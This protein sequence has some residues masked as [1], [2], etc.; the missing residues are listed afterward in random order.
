MQKR[1]SSHFWRLQFLDQGS[2]GLV[3][4]ET[5]LLGLQ[6]A[7]FPLRIHLVL[8]LYQIWVQ[9]SCYGEQLP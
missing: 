2:A 8:L 3:S 9:T 6:V 1:I 7:I 4:S 5:Y